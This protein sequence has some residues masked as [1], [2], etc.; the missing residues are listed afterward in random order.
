V[1][2]GVSVGE[3]DD[4]GIDDRC[5]R[6]PL[7]EVARRR[8]RL[9]QRNRIVGLAIVVGVFAI[10]FV[11]E[12]S[13]HATGLGVTLVLVVA[14]LA[15]NAGVCAWRGR[16]CALDLR[17]GYADRYFGVFQ[18]RLGQRGRR[19]E[20]LLPGR[21]RA[22]HTSDRQQMAH[23]HVISGRWVERQGTVDVAPHS[24][25]LLQIQEN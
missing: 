14:V 19:V 1:T 3:G 22:V 12:K 4:A 23:C 5:E 20:L 9:S 25:V 2:E 17:G 13:R 21:S 11:V 8:I 16:K 10:F 7:D 15:M 6:L 18:A 24:N